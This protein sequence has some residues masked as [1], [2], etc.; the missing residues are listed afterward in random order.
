MKINQFLNIFNEYTKNNCGTPY[1]WSINNKEF[2]CGYFNVFSILT[3][4]KS[5][6]LVHLPNV[7]VFIKRN[8]NF[9][10]NN[11]RF[12]EIYAIKLGP[13]VPMRIENLKEENFRSYLEKFKQIR[14][15]ADGLNIKKYKNKKLADKLSKINADFM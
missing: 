4:T 6:W 11:E 8:R 15:E 5:G 13:Y 14:D 3:K 2:K 10:F 12:N 1:V 7:S 9:I